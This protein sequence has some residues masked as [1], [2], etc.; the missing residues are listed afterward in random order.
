EPRPVGAGAGG[1]P[2]GAGPG[3]VRSGDPPRA[4]QVRPVA[5]GRA[6][7][8][9]RPQRLGHP[10]RSSGGAYSRAAGAPAP[11]SVRPVRRRPPAGPGRPPTPTPA[12]P[13]EGPPCRTDRLRTAMTSPMSSTPLTAV[14]PGA[15]L[16][17]VE[18]LAR[19]RSA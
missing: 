5:G 18:A 10:H 14:E 1:V 11:P 15:D 3:P 17:A 8:G 19:A 7:G 2:L 6:A 9:S 13:Q 4:A 12:G 16:R